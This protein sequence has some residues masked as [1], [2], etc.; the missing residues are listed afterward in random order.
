MS[1]SAFL[2]R[3]QGKR[4]AYD[5]TAEVMQLLDA[6]YRRIHDSRLPVHLQRTAHLEEALAFQPGLV[7]ARAAAADLALYAEALITAAR[8]NGHGELAEN[9]NDVAESLHEAVSKLAEAAHATVP[10]PQVPLVHAA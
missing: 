3:L 5:T 10:I 8:S 7:D 1:V 4:P 2:A 9:L 6:Q